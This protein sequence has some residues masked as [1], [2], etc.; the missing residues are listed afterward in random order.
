[1]IQAMEYDNE[2]D[3]LAEPTL[4]ELIDNNEN[5]LKKKIDATIINKFV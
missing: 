3:I 1:M 2:V 4:T 5:I